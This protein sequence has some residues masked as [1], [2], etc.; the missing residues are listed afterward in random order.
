VLETWLKPPSS[1]ADA[2]VLKATI[3]QNRHDFDAALVNLN[4]ALKLNPRLPQ[5]WLTQAAVYE[6]RGDYRAAIN[7]CLA[8]AR[9]ANQLTS[10]TC[11]NSALS[12]SGQAQSSYRQLAAT[13]GN[14]GS[15]EELTWAYTVLAELAERLGLSKAAESWYHL[16]INQHYRSVYLLSSYADFLLDQQRPDAVINLLKGETQADALLLRLTLAEQMLQSEGFS[17]HVNQIKDRVAAAHARGDK[18]HQG[19]EARFNLHILKDAK[20]ALALA[21]NN[22]VVQKE[23]RDAR[24]LLEAAIA[25]KQPE[26]AQP[27]LRFMEQTRLEDN[28]LLPLLKLAK[29]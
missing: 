7:S 24:I 28:R 22:W 19:D 8:V 16:A 17:G 26:A 13:V 9:Y 1:R 5:A 12:L 20:K 11:I 4:S 25:A 10:A 14:Q 23:P 18:V 6:V 21:V 27:V 2:L 29:G 3:L 15:P